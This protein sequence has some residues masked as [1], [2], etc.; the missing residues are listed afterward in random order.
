M[1]KGNKKELAYFSYFLEIVEKKL[2][3]LGNCALFSF[4][5]I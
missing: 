5:E 2:M 4:L 3:A 1:A